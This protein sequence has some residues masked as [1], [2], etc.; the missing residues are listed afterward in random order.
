MPDVMILIFAGAA[1]AASIGGW[2]YR[3]LFSRRGRARRALRKAR[4]LSIAEAR[5]GELVKLVGTLGLDG[6]TQV[7]A[8]LTGRPCAFFRTTVEQQQA[9]GPRNTSHWVTVIEESDFCPRFWIDD[10][11]GRALVELVLPEVVLQMDASFRSGFLNDATPELEAFL[12]RHSESS[13]GWVFNKAMRYREGA[14][15][16]GEEVAVYGL[17]RHEP[18][19]DP[20][21]GGG[22]RERPIR[23]KLI[24]PPDGRMLLSDDPKTL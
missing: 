14:L 4:K 15:E 12:N 23:R 13:Q 11:S 10:G 20:A 21:A 6:D 1:I 9:T 16:P 18:D 5:D 17:C 3:D 8:P 24:E 7:T 2:A 19:P 22:Y